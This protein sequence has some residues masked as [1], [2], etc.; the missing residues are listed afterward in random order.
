MFGGPED[1]MH[2]RKRK[3]ETNK[4]IIEEKLTAVHPQRFGCQRLKEAPEN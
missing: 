4:I 2:L 3:K 1:V